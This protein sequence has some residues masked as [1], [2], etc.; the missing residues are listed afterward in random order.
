MTNVFALDSILLVAE[1]QHDMVHSQEVHVIQRWVRG[2]ILAAVGGKVGI[3]ETKR[4]GVLGILPSGLEV[5]RRLENEEEGQ[6]ND[7]GDIPV[8]LPKAE[9]VC[10]KSVEELLDD[11]DVD[12]IGTGLRVI[13]MCIQNGACAVVAFGALSCPTPIKG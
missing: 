6:H 3:T 2:N 1:R 8:A 10:V 13:S 11:R 9:V 4:G 5:F 7:V 12:P